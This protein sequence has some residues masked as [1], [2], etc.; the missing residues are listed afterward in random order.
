ML[1]DTPYAV[2][3][4]YYSNMDSLLSQAGLRTWLVRDILQ[5]N[6]TYGYGFLAGII[7]SLGI[8]LIVEGL[9]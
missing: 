8:R 9:F 2:G 1:G 4:V 5:M 7:F 6:A 3:G